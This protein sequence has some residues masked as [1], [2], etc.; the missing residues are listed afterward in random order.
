MPRDKEGN[1][2]PTTA[3]TPYKRLVEAEILTEAQYQDL[4]ETYLLL[5]P[6]ALRNDLHEVT[7]QLLMME[8]SVR[9]LNEATE[10]LRSGF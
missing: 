3:K 6:V 7:I 1:L 10:D 2:P 5:N 8:S 4:Q 9:F